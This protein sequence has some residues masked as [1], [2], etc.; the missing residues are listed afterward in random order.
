MFF[1][2]FS[3]KAVYAAFT[4][5]IYNDD[6]VTLYLFSPSLYLA[7]PPPPPP[8]SNTNK[9]PVQNHWSPCRRLNRE[10]TAT[11]I[12]DNSIYR[13]STCV[14]LLLNFAT[15]LYK[16]PSDYWNWKCLMHFPLYE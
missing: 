3:N 12:M 10:N 8:P 15:F 11:K 4:D 2:T 14:C 6:S 7:P 16:S 5:S 9:P 13:N 1:I